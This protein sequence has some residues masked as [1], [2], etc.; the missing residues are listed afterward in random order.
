[1]E[2]DATLHMAVVAASHNDVLAAI[3]ADLG[4]VMRD[5]LRERHRRGAARPRRTW[6]T[7]GWST[8]IRAGD[9]E[10]A[11]AEAAGY[12]FMCRR[13]RGLP[14]VRPLAALVADPDR[15]GCPSS[16]AR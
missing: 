14:A 11:A 10:A 5:F 1:M 8:A 15:R 3:Y 13:V 9:A 7:R 12:P 6:T 16:T 4:E 2:A